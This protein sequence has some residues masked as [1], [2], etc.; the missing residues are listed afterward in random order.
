MN[1][2]AQQLRDAM[3]DDIHDFRMDAQDQCMPLD[4][5][6]VIEHWQQAYDLPRELAAYCYDALT[7]TSRYPFP[8]AYLQAFLDVRARKDCDSDE[9]RRAA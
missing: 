9:M 3:S 8:L 4:A 2:T 6:R 7:N 1:F 5:Q